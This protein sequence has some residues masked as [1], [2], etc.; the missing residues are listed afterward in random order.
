MKRVLFVCEGNRVRSQLAEA[1]LRHHAG[2]R[3]EAFSGGIRPGDV[4]PDFTIAALRESFY[5][6][7]GLT[8][9]HVDE[10]A[11]EEFDY[12]IV[13]CDTVRAKA[14]PL[15][16][17]KKRLDW[18]IED[19]RDAQAR[20]L[21]IDEALRENKTDLRSQIVRLM[22]S[23]GC[24]FCH[25]VDGEAEA[26]FLYRDELVDAFLDIRPVTEGHALVIPRE[27]YVTADELTEA[28]AGRMTHVA[29]RVAKALEASGIRFEGY[30]LF[31]ANGENAGQ[32]VFHVHLHVIPR[33]KNDGF[34]FRFPAG[35]GSRPPRQELDTMAARV[36]ELLD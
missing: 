6:A 8:P 2:D 21:S 36:R 20:G 14:P 3:F 32:E 7:D 19:P 27:H 9:N 17:A 1:M 4:V 15:P 26:S 10:F 13:L 25:I 11:G 31:V 22:E 16:R 12:L 5:P 18:T 35:Y 29:G 33:Y 34:G 28:I 30:N 24:I 23:E